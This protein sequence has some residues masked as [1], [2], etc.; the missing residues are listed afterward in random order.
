MP[1]KI[2]TLNN[3]SLKVPIKSASINVPKDQMEFVK[4]AMM[5]IKNTAR[6]SDVQIIEGEQPDLFDI[7]LDEEGI[8]QINEEKRRRSE[9]KK[10]QRKQE[11]EA[12]VLYQKQD[13]ET[14]IIKKMLEEERQEEKDKTL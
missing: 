8:A 11:K 7:E 12:K 13:V 10:K 4:S 9:E 1:T 3:L 5:D 6:I 2:H 14:D